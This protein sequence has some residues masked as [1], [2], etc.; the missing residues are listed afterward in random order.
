MTKRIAYLG[1]I[2]LLISSIISCEKDFQDIGTKVIGNNP[3]NT[4]KDTLDI[5]VDT[6]DVKN[7]RADNIA[8]GNLGQYLLGVYN[9]PDY[10]KIEASIVSQLG[11]LVNPKTEDSGTGTVDS[12]FTLDTVFVKIPY[13]ATN[14]GKE[15][16][17]KPKFRLDS[18]LGNA[19][20]TTSLKVY[21]NGTFL[22]TLD[23]T[24]PSKKN[25]YKS[26]KDYIE[27]EILN[28]DTFSFIP[29]AIDTMYFLNRKTSEG[30]IYKDTIKLSNNAPFLLVPLKTSRMK[31]LFWDKF[32]DPEFSTKVAFD[33]Y[34]RGLI[35]K[36]EG[37]DGALIPLDLSGTNNPTLEFHYTVTTFEGGR[38]KDTLPKSYAFPL[39]GIKNSIYK[40]SEQNPFPTNNI[41]VQGTAGTMAEVKLFDDTK[42]QELRTN[43]WLINDAS[44]IFYVNGNRDTTNVPRRLFAYKSGDVVGAQIKDAYSESTFFGG[45]LELADGKPEKYTI[46][47]TDYISDLLKSE[48]N[49]NP[50]L[51][52]KVYNVDTDAPVSDTIVKTYNWNPRAVS[53]LNHLSTNGDKKAKL[54]ISYTEEK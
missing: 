47:I 52:V 54:V 2:L 36:S 24:D 27:E 41:V 45:N 10:K 5:T 21:R 53:L 38:V 28:E 35:L 39:S 3:F 9:N 33:D 18:V 48:T 11:L 7:V 25:S 51:K 40:M 50:L 14:I 26:N 6:T 32:N 23:P 29:R 34:F 30:G 15:S 20:G 44:L 49:Y 19:Q 46:R 13:L 16:D 31:E 8:I 37:N 43:N 4:N 12:I 17:G 42:L 1:V 22:N